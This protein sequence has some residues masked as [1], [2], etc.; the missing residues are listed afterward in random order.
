MKLKRHLAAIFCSAALLTTGAA[1]APASAFP[2]EGTIIIDGKTFTVNRDCEGDNWHY[3]AKEHTL[4]LEGYE[5]LYIDLG[6]QEEGVTV[7]L[8]GNNRITSNVN[9]PALMSEGDLQITGEGVLE[10]DVSACH[11]AVYAKG[12]ALSISDTSVTV[13]GNGEVSEAA[14]MLMADSGLSILNS[15]IEIK[16]EVK[17]QGGAVGTISG[18]L[19]ITGSEIDI[20]SSEKALASLLGQVRLSGGKTVLSSSENAI[21]AKSGCAIEAGAK[22]EVTCKGEDTTAVYCPE[23]DIHVSSSELSVDAEKTALA[24]KYIILKDA[25]IAEPQEGMVR[26]ISSMCTISEDGKVASDVHILSGEKPTPTP[27]MSPTPV[28]LTPTNSP[29]PEAEGGS[30]FSVTPKMILGAGLLLVGVV[31]IVVI[32]LSRNRERN[33]Y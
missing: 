21:Y 2:E 33:Q 18:D 25:Y 12:A 26:E 5:G 6:P 20:S 7:N 16:D 9:I 27:T 8:S 15:K 32:L 31:V 30:G 4:F 11:C 10:L 3:E 13:K 19:E 28:T 23:G 24:G 29:A 22:V 1:M 17:G 14:Y